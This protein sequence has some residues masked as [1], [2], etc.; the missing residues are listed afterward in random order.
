MSNLPTN[1]AEL[2]MFILSVSIESLKLN[3]FTDNFDAAVFNADGVDRSMIFN[4]H[5]RV[6]YL[7]WL[8]EH[9][10]NIFS[11]YQLLSN[12]AS[13]SLYLSLFIYR[14]AGH[15]SFRIPLDYSKAGEEYAEYK[16]IENENA[17]NSELAFDGMFGK[18]KHF[19]FEYFGERYVADCFGL[20]TYLFSKQYFYSNEG[21]TIRPERGD[22][23]ID[24][25]GFTGD[26]ALVFSNAVGP[27]GRVYSFDPIEEHL[28]IMRFNGQR[29]PYRNVEVMPFGVSDSN[30]YANP[31]VLNHYSPGFRAETSVIPLR[32]LDFLVECDLVKRI[33]FVKLD[34][35]GS[36]AKALIGAI[37]SIRRFK[38]KLAISLYHNPNDLFTLPLLVK[39]LFP[40]YK[41]FCVGHYSIHVGESVLYVSV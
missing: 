34:V 19:D 9:I 24:G 36:E 12:D 27:E 38:P 11:A 28:E 20:G 1:S 33:D 25:G 35:E 21:G 5:E 29:F 18:L 23:V 22:Y 37:E 15:H 2:K 8:I 13:R 4:T 16:K 10:E 30:V 26:T 31:L 39:H 17:A 32:T 40:F 3:T 41:H 7:E 6:F 14:L